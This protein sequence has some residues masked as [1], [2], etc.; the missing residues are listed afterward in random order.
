MEAHEINDGALADAAQRVDR[1]YF[2]FKALVDD[3]DRHNPKSKAAVL[4]GL[5]PRS[6]FVHEPNAS[7]DWHRRRERVPRDAEIIGQ[8]LC[9]GQRHAPQ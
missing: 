4:V 8:P 6:R 2:L 3:T 1:L 9:L 5:E 7:R